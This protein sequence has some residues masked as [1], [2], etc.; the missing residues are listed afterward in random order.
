MIEEMTPEQ[1]LAATYNAALDSVALVDTLAAKGTLTE[2]EQDTL[3]RNVE[4]L[5]IVVAKEGLT[6]AEVATLQA[7]I[8]KG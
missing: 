1:E 4:H 8:D 5:K 6:A 2:E 7:A 3:T